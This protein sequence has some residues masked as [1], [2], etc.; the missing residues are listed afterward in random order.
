MYCRFDYCEETEES[1]ADKSGAITIY[2]YIVP[3]L[4]KCYMKVQC[5][6]TSQRT[7]NKY[8]EVG[9][10]DGGGGRDPKSAKN[11]SFISPKKVQSST[12]MNCLLCA[13]YIPTQCLY[14]PPLTSSEQLSWSPELKMFLIQIL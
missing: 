4:Q 5:V 1:K 12:S 11:F 6:S 7:V 8:F 10:R 13:S 3:T 14:L 9:W 2:V